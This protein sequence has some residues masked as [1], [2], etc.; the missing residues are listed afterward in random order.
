MFRPSVTVAGTG[1]GVGG[2]VSGILNT[3]THPWEPPDLCKVGGSPILG[4]V[5][6]G[7]LPCRVVRFPPP[8]GPGPVSPV[9]PVCH[10]PSVG[11]AV[12]AFFAGRDLAA[13][14]CRTYRQAL[15]P[16]VETVGA[17]RPVTDL[18]PDQ[19]AAVFEELWADRAPA[20]WNTRRGRH[21]GVRFV[22]W[23][24]VAPGRR[25]AGRGW[26]PAAGGPITPGRSRW[27]I[28]RACGAAGRCRFGRNRCGG[29]CMRPP[30]ERRRCWLWMWGTWTGPGGG[31]VSAPRGQHGHGCVGG[32]HRPPLG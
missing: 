19:V 9:H 6:A 8:V 13:G 5:E 17:D 26:S 2:W 31:P 32:A 7:H 21:P 1:P 14:T 4:V 25:S 20:T 23:G 3:P 30:P 29:C 24:P 16:L 10:A 11:W 27:E 18:C 22:V 12:E 15:G 28:S